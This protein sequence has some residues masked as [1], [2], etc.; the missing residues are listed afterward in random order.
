MYRFKSIL[1][2]VFTNKKVSNRIQRDFLE[3]KNN[4]G[5]KKLRTF[6]LHNGVYYANNGIIFIST[7]TSQSDIKNLL[8]LFKAGL[9]KYIR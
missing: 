6:L 8:K 7:Q 1:R 5:A 3:K 2:L 9:K 4:T